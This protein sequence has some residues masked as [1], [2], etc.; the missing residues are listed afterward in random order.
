MAPNPFV[1]VVVVA[2]VIVIVVLLLSKRECDT[3]TGDA[4]VIA[5]PQK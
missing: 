4:G 5:G 3:Y 2:I 1:E